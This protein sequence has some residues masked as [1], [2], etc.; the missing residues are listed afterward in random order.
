[1]I[2]RWLDAARLRS[3]RVFL[4]TVARREISLSGLVNRLLKLAYLLRNFVNHGEILIA[5]VVEQ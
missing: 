5:D 2:P 1:M 4:R 3:V